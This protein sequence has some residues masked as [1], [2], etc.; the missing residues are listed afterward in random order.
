MDDTARTRI[1]ILLIFVLL[2]DRET[3]REK[4]RGEL[5]HALE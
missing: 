3:G 1:R 4:G 2:S 5:V